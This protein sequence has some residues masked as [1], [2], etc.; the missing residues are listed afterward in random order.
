MIKFLVRIFNTK[1]ICKILVI[2]A[3]GFIS[4]SLVN[5]IFDTDV[6]K[7]FTSVVSLFYYSSFACFLCLLGSLVDFCDY[8]KMPLGGSG[9]G[10]S[11]DKK[12]SNVSLMST[13]GIDS[14]DEFA[15]DTSSE[16]D[17]SFD[18]D[19]AEEEESTERLVEK[20]KD[21]P[22]ELLDYQEKRVDDLCKDY[23]N[24]VDSYLEERKESRPE[25]SED[26]NKLKEFDQATEKEAKMWID[27][28]C[29]D[30]DGINRCRD[31]VLINT[32]HYEFVDRASVNDEAIKDDVKKHQKDAINN[33]YD[34]GSSGDNDSK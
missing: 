29:S 12:L 22:Q 17:Y 24:E 10:Y 16:N 8:F 18:P 13:D 15:S 11:S 23:K 5:Y 6:F 2:F 28:F 30:L 7:D 14:S 34:K 4:R 25:L 33:Y 19:H 20:Y 3:V 26:K 31:D 21:K 27:G 1:S 32:D 9:P